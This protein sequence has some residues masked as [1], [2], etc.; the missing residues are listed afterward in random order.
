MI[1]KE[2]VIHF[3]KPSLNR[4]ILTIIALSVYNNTYSHSHK[5][6]FRGGIIPV[7]LFPSFYIAYMYVYYPENFNYKNKNPTI[8][9]TGLINE[10]NKLL[11]SEIEIL[12]IVSMIVNIGYIE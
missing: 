3:F 1:R 2:N 11:G 5:K 6:L 8:P 7:I 12:F 10:L 9:E 4:I